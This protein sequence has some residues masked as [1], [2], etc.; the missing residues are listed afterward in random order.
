MCTEAVA[1]E[2]NSAAPCNRNPVGPLGG[3][4]RRTE[5]EQ[6]DV[7]ALRALCVPFN[8]VAGLPSEC[9]ATMGAACVSAAGVAMKRHNYTL[10][11][12]ARLLARYAAIAVAV[13]SRPGSNEAG[14]LADIDV[15]LS[16]LPEREFQVLE[17]R[18]LKRL[19][20]VEVAQVFSVHPNTA[21]R[22]Y[23]TALRS[24]HASL[25]GVSSTPVIRSVEWREWAGSNVERVLTDFDSSRPGGPG[26]PPTI[27]REMDELV[28]RLHCAGAKEREIVD[29]LQREFPRED[30]GAWTRSSVRSVLRRYHAPRRP[31]GPRPRRGSYRPGDVTRANYREI[32]LGEPFCD[33]EALLLKTR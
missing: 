15:A 21:S 24:V 19:T 33:A 23:M 2:E 17:L 14:Q 25:N 4:H 28:L 12:V 9:G 10:G 30:N 26:R 29:V 22:R 11:E 32:E 18:G 6:G 8:D 31:R 3:C 16:R 7:E 27:S 1:A 20:N 13:E 5:S